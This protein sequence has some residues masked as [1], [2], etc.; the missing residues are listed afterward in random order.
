MASL[1]AAWSNRPAGTVVPWKDDDA[2]FMAWG[3]LVRGVER[4][5]TGRSPTGP[6]PALL[7]AL[8][9]NIVDGTP[10]HIHAVAWGV[11]RACHAVFTNGWIAEHPEPFI[12][13]PNEAYPVDSWVGPEDW[14]YSRNPANFVLDDEFPHLR[15]YQPGLGLAEPIDIMF[16]PS[17]EIEVTAALEGFDT[18][19]T[20]HPND[21]W[22]ELDI[23][24]GPSPYP[25][26]PSLDSQ[27]DVLRRGIEAALGAGAAVVVAGELCSTPRISEELRSWLAERGDHAIVVAGSY[28]ADADG[29]PA[30]LTTTLIADAE[31]HTLVHQKIVPFTVDRHG[32][33]PVREGIVGGPRRVHI[34]VAGGFRFATLIC[35]DFLDDDVRAAVKRAGVNVLAVPSMSAA[36]DSYPAEVAKFVEDSQGVAVVANNPARRQDDTPIEP[37]AVYGQPLASHP[38]V[39]C[40]PFDQRNARFVGVHRLGEAEARWLDRL[41]LLD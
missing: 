3:D 6:D 2:T 21:A 34:L 38:A 26:A 23:P 30:N 13:A 37:A 33:V 9:A 19:A 10:W 31:S 28:H 14:D 20:V 5:L 18:V 15:R 35:K 25:I 27:Y 36:M 1:A 12:P 40:P 4:T 11:D 39:V 8:Q 24:D 7:D 32:D 17:L 22:S 16:D 41:K 29:R